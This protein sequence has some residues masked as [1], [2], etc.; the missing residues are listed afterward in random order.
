[1]D[2]SCFRLYLYRCAQRRLRAALAAGLPGPEAVRAVLGYL[3]GMYPL[4]IEGWA[5]LAVA[6]F[7][8]AGDATCLDAPDGR[9]E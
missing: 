3:R 2:R 4:E 7:A 5:R 9:S 1:M 8:S 6:L